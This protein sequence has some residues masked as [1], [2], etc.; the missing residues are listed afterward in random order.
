VVTVAMVVP[1]SVA[2]A[3]AVTVTFAVRE[4]GGRQQQGENQYGCDY[5]CE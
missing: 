2:V 5:R 1:F 3:V 4:R